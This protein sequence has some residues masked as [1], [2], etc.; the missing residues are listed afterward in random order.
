MEVFDIREYK[1]EY[2]YDTNGYTQNCKH[3]GY[4]LVTLSFISQ[5]HTDIHM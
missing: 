5:Y 4:P 1:G 2:I 3:V